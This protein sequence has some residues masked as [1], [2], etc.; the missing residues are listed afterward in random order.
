VVPKESAGAQYE[1]TR[2]LMQRREAAPG[3]EQEETA[4]SSR[5]SK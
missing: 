4:R 5:N 3:D 2:W 1:S